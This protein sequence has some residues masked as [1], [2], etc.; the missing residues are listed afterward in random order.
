M[1]KDF[2]SKYRRYKIA[3]ALNQ[4]FEDQ[5][6]NKYISFLDSVFSKTIKYGFKNKRY[7]GGFCYVYDSK[8]I[9]FIHEKLTH[10]FILLYGMVDI[11]K[12]KYNED[13]KYDELRYQTDDMNLLSES[14]I[15]YFNFKD[16]EKSEF[17][18]ITPSFNDISILV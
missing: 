9:L 1:I 3:K 7:K 6:F 17:F 2:K 11:V 15:E 16:V 8:K 10:E 5:E 14:I 12:D 18:P 13:G 4:E